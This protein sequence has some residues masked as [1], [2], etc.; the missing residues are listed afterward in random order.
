[1]DNNNQQNLNTPQQPQQPIPP[2]NKSRSIVAVAIIVVVTALVIVGGYIAYS[3]YQ[4]SPTPQNQ[5]NNAINDSD[6]Q[7]QN[8]VSDAKFSLL[9]TLHENVAGVAQRPSIVL[10]NPSQKSRQVIKKYEQGSLINSGKI[11]ADN[12][13]ANENF[14]YILND[15]TKIS[16]VKSDLSGNV[17]NT[18]T[19]DQ[20]VLS[21]SQRVA[22]SPNGQK[23]AW[24][25]GGKGLAVYDFVSKNN[26]TFAN[27]VACAL[28]SNSLAFSRDNSKIYYIKGF[29]ELYGDYTKEEVEKLA[30]EAKN[31]LHVIDLSTGEDKNITT[32]SVVLW[33]SPSINLEQKIVIAPLPTGYEDTLEVK[34]LNDI[35]FDY[36]TS[37]QISQLPTVTKLQLPNRRYQQF[38]LSADG[39]GIFYLVSP[40]GELNTTGHEIGYFDIPSNKN[41]FPIPNIRK[42]GN[43]SVF[44]AMNKDL[45]LY[46]DDYIKVSN[47]TDWYNKTETR[48]YKTTVQGQN[49]LVDTV[50]GFISLLDI[51]S[52]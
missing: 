27:N 7:Q 25:Q 4:S 39:S 1:M 26:K 22:V 46:R 9:Y 43:L 37:E 30:R 52:Q 2:V 44:V 42:D 19:V 13:Y 24:C 16:L 50:V 18:V 51:V 38:I 21:Y 36:L 23:A 32:A 8:V 20:N 6:N 17:Q 41:F 29:W 45:L 28:G 48:I 31:G 12:L 35:N 34:K 3:R 14:Y 49:E 40:E 11:E 47:D 15:G 5:Q 10:Y 33:N